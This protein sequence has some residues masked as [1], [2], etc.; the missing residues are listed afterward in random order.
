MGD[1]CAVSPRS[2]RQRGLTAAALLHLL[3]VQN[4]KYTDPII[5]D[6]C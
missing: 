3:S 2:A 4:R 6:Y 1:S 5:K